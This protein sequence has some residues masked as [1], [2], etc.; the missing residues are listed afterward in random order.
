MLHSLCY[1]CRLWLI[2]YKQYRMSIAPLKKLS[3]KNPQSVFCRDFQSTIL[4]LL[5]H[6]L[7]SHDHQWKTIDMDQKIYSEVY[8]LRTLQWLDS[9]KKFWR[10]KLSL[11][12]VI[13]S[14]SFHV[15]NAFSMSEVV[16]KSVRNSTYV[17]FFPSNYDHQMETVNFTVSFI[18]QL[19]MNLAPLM[20]NQLY[21]STI[22]YRLYRIEYTINF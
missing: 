11:P 3:W 6:L 16:S 19:A 12:K 14:S 15:K 5:R 4:C 9:G 21:F 7:Y 17:E 20:L 8:F 18:A 1:V 2:A 22:R 13:K 10:I